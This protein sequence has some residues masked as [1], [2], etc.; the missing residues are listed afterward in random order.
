MTD[1]EILRKDQLEIRLH[2]EKKL[3]HEGALK[4]ENP[5]DFSEGFR[6]LCEACRKGD[7]KIC[8]EKISEGVN[9]N[10]RDSYDYTPLILVRCAAIDN[11][12]GWLLTQNYRQVYAG[13]SKSCNF[14]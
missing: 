9:I 14:F 10:A 8:Q 11:A 6:Q 4:D 1:S 5:L 12:S 3:I 13:I 2:N 7:L